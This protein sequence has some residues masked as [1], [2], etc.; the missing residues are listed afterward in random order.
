MLKFKSYQG[1]LSVITF[2]ALIGYSLL[3][4]TIEIRETDNTEHRALNPV[5]AGVSLVIHKIIKVGHI[6]KV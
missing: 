4:G 5:C 1:S 6:L 3:T 2:M